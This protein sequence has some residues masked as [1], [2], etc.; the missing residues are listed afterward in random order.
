MPIYEYA[1]KKCGDFEATQRITEAALKKCPSCGSKVS[2]LISQSAFHLKG[3]GWYVTDFK[4]G[5][6]SSD[7]KETKDESKSG[8]KDESKSESKSESKGESKSESKGETKSESK[9][10][11]KSETQSE[12]KSDKKSSSSTSSSPA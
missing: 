9:S 10:E 4:N 2:K 3:S 6:S 8:T 1:C 7:A 12:S 11:S 5:K